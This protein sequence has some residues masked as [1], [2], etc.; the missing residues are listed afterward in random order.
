[1]YVC[2]TG[3]RGRRGRGQ[4]GILGQLITNARI[5]ALSVR[6]GIAHLPDNTCMYVVCMYVCMYV[7]Q[8]VLSYL[9][10]ILISVVR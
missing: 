9:L 2:G 7:W 3:G 4:D 1:M 5:A 10:F 6:K 8:Q